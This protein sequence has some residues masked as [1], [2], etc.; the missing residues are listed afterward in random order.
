MMDGDQGWGDFFDD[1][2]KRNSSIISPQMK[3]KSGLGAGSLGV[4]YSK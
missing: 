4:D 2:E 3:Q 1:G